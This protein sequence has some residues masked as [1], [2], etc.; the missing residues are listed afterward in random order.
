ME[1]SAELYIDEYNRFYNCQTLYSHVVSEL[2][3]KHIVGFRL[4]INSSV[5]IITSGQTILT[6]G[7]IADLS[8]LPAAMDSSDFD[9]YLEYMV[10]WTHWSQF[11]KRHRFSRFAYTTAKNPDAFQ[12]AG[13]TSEIASSPRG[14]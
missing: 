5:L 12:W 13:Q 10:P 2:K 3:I 4:F 1:I 14:I 8:S 11:P 7:R 9:P 6:K